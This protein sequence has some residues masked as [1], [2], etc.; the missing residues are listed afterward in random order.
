MQ[1]SI[2][3]GL[4]E[5]HTVKNTLQNAA[6]TVHKK[7]NKLQSITEIVNRSQAITMPQKEKDLM[8][9]K[10]VNKINDDQEVIN[11]FK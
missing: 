6:V 8:N 5:S 4:K 9:V 3:K 10:S 11:D 1:K 7:I 2:K